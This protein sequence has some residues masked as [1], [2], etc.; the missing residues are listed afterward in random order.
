[1]ELAI[2][3]V[4]LEATSRTGITTVG[5]NQYSG[6][7]TAVAYLAGPSD[8]IDA[9]ERERGWRDELASRGLQARRIGIGDWSPSAGYSFG[10]A[11]DLE[12]LTAVFVSND[13]MAVGL[14]HA[15][16]DRGRSV[17]RDVSIVGF[18]DVPEAEHLSPPLTTV[19]QDFEHIGRDMLSVLLGRI[20]G[21]GSPLPASVPALIERSS[22]RRL[23]A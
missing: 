7:R 6:A 13:Q 8:S 23:D 19:R 1:M 14:M 18:D 10:M 21:D 2:P 16:S 15:L 5:A 3:V 4:A 17:P 20:N 9:K 11:C 12:G 22:T